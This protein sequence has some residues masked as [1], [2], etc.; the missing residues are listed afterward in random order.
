VGRL[1]RWRARLRGVPARDRFVRLT[2]VSV[3][4]IDDEVTVTVPIR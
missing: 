2:A 4:P 1:T 3:D